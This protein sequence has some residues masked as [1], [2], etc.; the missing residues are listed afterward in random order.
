MTLLQNNGHSNLLHNAEAA[1]FVDE[2][3]AIINTMRGYHGG[4]IP[5]DI[6]SSIYDDFRDKINI[7][8]IERMNAIN[9]FFMSSLGQN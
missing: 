5:D 3:N 2:M 8:D 9:D 7:L 1:G 6:L 4:N